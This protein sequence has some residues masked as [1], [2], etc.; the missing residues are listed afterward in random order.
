MAEGDERSEI[1]E[2]LEEAGVTTKPIWWLVSPEI[3]R[4]TATQAAANVRNAR[5]RTTASAI[6]T[7]LLLRLL[8]RREYFKTLSRY[9]VSP[10]QSAG[11]RLQL[12]VQLSYQS[13]PACGVL[14]T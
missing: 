2:L 9:A 14:N 11:E 13:T 4:I 1:S 7:R 3:Q 6:R 12:S 8:T 10:K 5:P